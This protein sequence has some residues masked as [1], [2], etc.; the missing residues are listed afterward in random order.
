MKRIDHPNIIKLIDVYETENSLEL[1]LEYVPNGSLFQRMKEQDR[2]SESVVKNYA[3]D[4]VK[5]V[6]YL[7]SFP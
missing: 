2:L 5:A 3:I 4:I 1:L 6:K 7:H